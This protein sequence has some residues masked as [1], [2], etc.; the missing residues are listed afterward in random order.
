MED[1]FARI[2]AVRGI[3]YSI[4]SSP[5]ISPYLISFKDKIDSLS[6]SF[7]KHSSSPSSNI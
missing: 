7:F 6:I 2:V 3:L 1:F 4:E 5:K